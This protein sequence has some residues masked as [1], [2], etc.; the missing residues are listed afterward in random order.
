MKGPSIL[1]CRHALPDQIRTNDDPVFQGIDA[2]DSAEELRLFHGMRERRVLEEDQNITDLMVAASRNALEAA[3]IDAEEIRRV[4]GY[5]SLS[6][7]RAPNSL[8]EVHARLGL[9]RDCAVLPLHSEFDG[10][11]LALMLARDAWLGADRGPF[12][13][14]VG[15]TWSR[16]V[17][18]S[19]PHSLA[20]GDGA[21]ALVVGPGDHML[22]RDVAVAVDGSRYGHIRVAERS[23]GVDPDGRTL[24]FRPTFEITKA[25][26]ADFTDFGAGELPVL[27]HRLLRGNDVSPE[28]VTFIGHQASQHLIDAWSEQIKPGRYLHTFPSLGNMTSASAAVTLA[29]HGDEVDTPYLVLGGVGPGANA[30][31]VL[32]E[33]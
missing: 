25:G 17:D 32:I 10:V 9:R 6:E 30:S 8:Y 13:V 24:F 27:V 18:Y 12:L 11:I 22:V 15:S 5:A 4:Y 7:Y 2:L 21:A 31:A 1:S 19:K 26:R 3:R 20:V 16:G 28:D 33:C 14:T 23:A 29:L